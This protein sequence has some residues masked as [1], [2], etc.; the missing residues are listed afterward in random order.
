MQILNNG[1]S[2]EILKSRKF[3]CDCGCVF[4]ADSKD[5]FVGA[6]P[7]DYLCECPQCHQEVTMS[8]PIGH[9]VWHI[10]FRPITDSDGQSRSCEKGY[11]CS[12]CGFFSHYATQLCLNCNSLMRRDEQ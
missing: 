2:N 12:A 7:N 6:M 8:V 3:Y 1:N 11:M 4:V 5:Y 9:A 10:N